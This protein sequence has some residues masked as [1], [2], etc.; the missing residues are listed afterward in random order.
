MAELD[1]PGSKVGSLDCLHCGQRL[2]F[3]RVTTPDGI[4][5][6][7][8]RLS[9]NVWLGWAESDGQVEIVGTCGRSCLDRYLLARLQPSETL[10]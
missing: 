2:R 10:P 9:P 8:Q 1:L 3:L 5:D 4:P 7:I 6:F